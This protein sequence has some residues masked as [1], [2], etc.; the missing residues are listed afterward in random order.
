MTDKSS[1]CDVASATQAPRASPYFS[2]GLR[3]T[4]SA[5]ARCLEKF[6]CGAQDIYELFFDGV[7]G[8][9]RNVRL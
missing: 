4:V 5:G 8:L 1:D 7:R 9:S 3:V 6:G 2:L